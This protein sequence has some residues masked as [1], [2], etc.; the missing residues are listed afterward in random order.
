MPYHYYRDTDNEYSSDEDSSS[1]VS[2][3][4]TDYSDNEMNT[5]IDN[6]DSSPNVKPY[7]E[8]TYCFNVLDSKIIN[9]DVDFLIFEETNNINVP[10]DILKSLKFRSPP[11][12]GMVT[13]PILGIKT[14]G[15]LEFTA[16]ENSCVLPS[17]LMEYMN[18]ESMNK[19][20]F[21]IIRKVPKGKFVLLEPQEKEFFNTPEDI[22]EFLTNKLS[23]FGVL[24]EGLQFNC[25]VNTHS[26]NFIVRQVKGNEIEEI[27]KGFFDKEHDYT[28][29]MDDVIDVSN[30]DLEVDF[31]NKFGDLKF[32][33]SINE[34]VNRLTEKVTDYNFSNEDEELQRSLLSQFTSVKEE[35]K[36]IDTDMSEMKKARLRWLD[37]LE[38]EIKNDDE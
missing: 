21:K 3:I 37:K 34:P 29:I 38:A 22:K 36:P 18:L 33:Q 23:K 12:I 6:N 35:S 19:I 9:N 26:Y 20:N 11:Y 27:D 32:D 1:G 24:F 14:F 30:V 8:E 31:K 5:S 25:Q 17:W 15:K 2:H 16:P 28:P 10:H 4:S 13:N 7:N